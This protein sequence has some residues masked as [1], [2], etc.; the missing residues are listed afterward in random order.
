MSPDLSL[1]L[2]TDSA[3]AAQAGHQLTDV[4]QQAVAG[5]VSTVQIREKNASAKEFLLTVQQISAVLPVSV[6]LLVND[7]IDVFLAARDSGTKL[8]GV[9]IGQSD[10]PVEAVR[11]LIGQDALLGLSAATP[12]QLERAANSP[13]RIDYL[14]IGALNPTK[15]KDDAPPALGLDGFR[16][17]LRHCTLPAVAIGGIGVADLPGLRVAGAAGAAV[18]S[19]ICSAEDPRR[20][21]QALSLAWQ[22]AL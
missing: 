17:L 16:E 2:V 10:L 14:G 3:L 11:K 19:A 6:T 8:D 4:V 20:A 13:A 15:T 12:E 18:V 21:A 1:Y 22:E 5:G 9:H 7:R